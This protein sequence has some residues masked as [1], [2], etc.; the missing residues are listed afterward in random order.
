MSFAPGALEGVRV[1]DLTQ[2]ILGP[3]CTQM[4]GD[5]GADVIKVE[6]PGGDRQ[7]TSGRAPKSDTMG[8]AFI[9]LNRNK[10]S[11]ALDLKNEPG[12]KALAK[13]IKGADIFVHNMRLSAA[14]SPGC[15]VRSR[16][17]KTGVPP[18]VSEMP[19]SWRRGARAMRA[20]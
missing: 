1:V 7:R 19:E 3:Y 15:T 11:L 10:R 13:L 2:Y 20:R 12:R 18:K 6:E 9:S 16:L 5:L 8:P 17:S 14:R 4:L